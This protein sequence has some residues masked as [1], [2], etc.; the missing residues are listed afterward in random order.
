MR[1][2]L[3]EPRPTPLLLVCDDDE[4]DRLLIQT[5]LGENRLKMDIHLVED[6]EELLD[7]LLRRGKHSDLHTQRLPDLILLDLRMP[8]MDGLEVLSAIKNE[9]H[10]RYIPVVI[11]TTSRLPEDITHSYQLGANS[12]IIKPVKYDLLVE[13]LQAIMEYWFNVVELPH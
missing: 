8:K 13:R 12:Y 4:D 7:Y 6:G 11:L 2:H 5:A 1:R 3:N 9:E 10:L